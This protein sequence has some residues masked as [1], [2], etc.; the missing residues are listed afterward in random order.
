MAQEQEWASADGYLEISQQVN[1]VESRS[2]LHDDDSQSPLLGLH[3]GYKCHDGENEVKHE[4]VTLCQHGCA[5]EKVLEI[6]SLLLQEWLSSAPWLE[7]VGCEHQFW[8][9]L[10]DVIVKELDQQLILGL[11]WPLLVFQ[12]QIALPQ[13]CIIPVAVLAQ[14]IELTDP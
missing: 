3:E 7:Y 1:L 14:A 5:N 13:A 12:Q 2:S 4:L 11:D 9:S 10:F 6:F 8:C